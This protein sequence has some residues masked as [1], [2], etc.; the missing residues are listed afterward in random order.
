MRKKPIAEKKRI[1]TLICT[2]LLGK[3]P[4]NE[5]GKRKKEKKYRIIFILYYI[6]LL[7]LVFGTERN[8]IYS[9]TLG[10]RY[11]SSI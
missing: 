7:Y 8:T 3:K 9:C 10:L 1:K 4:V 11:F 6:R 2:P 5:R